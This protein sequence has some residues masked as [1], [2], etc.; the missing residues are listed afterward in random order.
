[1]MSSREQKISELP[2]IRQ[3]ILDCSFFAKKSLGQNFL[4]D[5]NITR[6]IARLAPH[7]NQG[8]ILE[9]GPGPGSLTRALFW[10]GA[11]KVIAIDKDPRSL[12]ALS[13]LQDIVGHQLDVIIDDALHI[14]LHT[15]GSAPRQVIANLPYNVATPILI[16]LLRNIDDFSALTLMF[17]KE[18]AERLVAKPRTN[19]YGRL[20]VIAQWCCD[21]RILF[22]LPPSAF[23]PAP[24]IISSVVQLIP[25]KNRPF[26]KFL[27]LENTTHRFFQNR[28]KML[29][30]NLKSI[31]DDMQNKLKQD[32]ILLSMRPEELTVEQFCILANTTY[33]NP[34]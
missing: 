11:Q 6:R 18:V 12:C 3:V 22:D 14:S 19:S 21:V 4:L 7:L 2:P 29:R 17:Q 28:R 20:S 26:C 27:L 15:L 31:T 1:M 24:K 16:N 33:E 10:E 9:I 32:G 30:S 8:T 34:E 5:T 25:R 13:Q 23:V